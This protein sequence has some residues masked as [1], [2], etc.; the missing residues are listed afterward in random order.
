[1]GKF[2]P[3]PDEDCLILSLH[4]S[5]ESGAEGKEKPQRAD[6]LQR[7][8]SFDVVFLFLS[9]SLFHR[10]Y[11]IITPN[12][13]TASSEQGKAACCSKKL[14]RNAMRTMR[15]GRKKRE[16]EWGCSDVTE[17]RASSHLFRALSSSLAKCVHIHT[18]G[19][20]NVI[21]EMW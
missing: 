21:A 20:Q 6:P 18:M 12:K 14:S 16:S 2:S 13:R 17:L 4:H 7:T 11:G 15:P 3:H 5:G 8:I 19:T 1:M 10:H 9:H